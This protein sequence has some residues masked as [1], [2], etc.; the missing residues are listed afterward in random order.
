MTTDLLRRLSE[1]FGPSG[2]EDEVRDILTEVVTPLVDEIRVDKLGNLIATKRG[3][4]DRVLLLDAHMDEVGFLVSYIEDNGFLRLHPLGGWDARV[5]P[6]H[7]VTVKGRDGQRIRGVIGTLPPHITAEAERSKA[8]RLEDLFVDIGASSRAAAE[9]LGVEVGSPCAPGY[10]FEQLD[11]DLVMGKAFDDRAGCTV[12]VGVLDALRDHES[13]MTLVC[14]F[15]VSEELGLRGAQTVAHQIRPD[16]ALALEGTT[17]VDVPGVGGA[18]KLA[19]MGAGPAVTIADRSIVASRQVLTLLEE[20]AAK[21]DIPY[22]RKLPGGGGTDAGAIQ[23]SGD[24]VLV[25][26]VSVPCRYIH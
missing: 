3:R 1:A 9:S 22:Q 18:R 15:P 20:V 26:V 8:H 17:A 25:G 13:D 11:D 5:L 10:P 21:E 6:A 23:T 7:A 16:V 24:G 12:A 2:F 14:A 19:S 4:S